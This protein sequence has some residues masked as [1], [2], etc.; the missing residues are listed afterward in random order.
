MQGFKKRCSFVAKYQSSVVCILFQ[1]C[2]DVHIYKKT[3]DALDRRNRK[4]KHGY[5][6]ERFNLETF[7]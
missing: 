1:D 7:C 4:I 6:Y 2:F 5:I 3:E